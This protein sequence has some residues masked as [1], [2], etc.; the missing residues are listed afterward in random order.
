VE[1]LCSAPR[2]DDLMWYW[3]RPKHIVP[4]G[5]RDRA[6]WVMSRSQALK[7]TDGPPPMTLVPS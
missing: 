4:I 5:E 2:A 3:E 1:P 7:L 6:S